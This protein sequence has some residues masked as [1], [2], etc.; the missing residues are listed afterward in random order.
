[1]AGIEV[2][3]I[4]VK[5]DRAE[6][7]RGVAPYFVVFANKMI[8]IFKQA[9]RVRTDRQ[10]RKRALEHGRQ[11]CSAQ[12]FAGNIGYEKSR[13]RLVHLE[14]VKVVPADSKA[15]GVHSGNGQMWELS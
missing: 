5:V 13:A 15:R 4:S 12:P 9:R 1:M 8:V 3:Q 14:Y 2:L 11:Q 7:H 6:K 10:A